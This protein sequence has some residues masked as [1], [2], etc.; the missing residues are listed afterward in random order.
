M[1]TRHYIVLHRPNIDIATA[2]WEA[3]VARQISNE[4]DWH[5]WWVLGGRWEDELTE[6]VGKTIWPNALPHKH[7]LPVGEF[8]AQA[9]GIV[10]QT[11]RE[12]NNEINEVRRLINNTPL[13]HDYV[14]DM[15]GG[16][17]PTAAHLADWQARQDKEH[18]DYAALFDESKGLEELDKTY[19]FAAWRVSRMLKIIRGDWC[20]DSYF[21]D[22]TR[23]TANPTKLAQFLRGTDE[24]YTQYS[25]PIHINDLYI[26]VVDFHC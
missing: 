1:H 4:D 21:L 12:Q 6:K 24:S 16:K 13:P 17:P 11:L 25:T 23:G 22:T 8:R 2:D 19:N 14:P 20:P 15:W 9:L 26:V 10:E 7:V 5:D 18:P 3:Q